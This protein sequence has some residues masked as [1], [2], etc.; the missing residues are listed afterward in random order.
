MSVRWRRALARVA[1]AMVAASVPVPAQIEVAAAVAS[2]QVS[3][4]MRVV[5]PVPVVEQPL[6]AEPQAAGLEERS[7]VASEARAPALLVLA[8]ALA[9]AQQLPVRTHQMRS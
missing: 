6:R 2:L 4:P 5:A 1:A 9:L 7:P 3:A 8:L